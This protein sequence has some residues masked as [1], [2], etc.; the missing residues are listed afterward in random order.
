MKRIFKETQGF[1]LIELIVVIAIIGILA[2]IAIPAYISI[3]DDAH[4]ANVD[5]VGGAVAA[6]TNLEAADG[7]VATGLWAYP[8]ESF[9]TLPVVFPAS[10]PPDNWTDGAAGTLV[11]GGGSGGEVVYTSV[12]SQPSSYVIVRTYAGS[13]Y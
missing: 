11:Y 7:L 9:C 13:T 5:A 4:R 10:N 12:T 1:T 3:T 2:A 8:A 6:W